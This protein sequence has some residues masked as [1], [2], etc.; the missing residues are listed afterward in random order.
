MNALRRM[1][2]VR[3]AIVVV[4]AFVAVGSWWTYLHAENRDAGS[5]HHAKYHCPMHPNV[6]S[7][8]PGSCPICGMSLELIA[9]SSTSPNMEDLDSGVPG[10]SAVTLTFDRMQAIG[11]KMATAIERESAEPLR[12]TASIAPPDQGFAEVHVRTPGFVE[13]IAVRET[14]VHVAAGQELFAM[15]SPEITQAQAELVAARAI[16]AGP[17]ADVRVTDAAR[18]KLDL[19]GMPAHTI[20]DVAKTGKAARTVSVVAPKA[21]WVNKKNVVLGSYVTP[22][23]TL[24]EIVD[25][26]RVYVVADIFA[27]DLSDVPVGARG[28]FVVDGKPDLTA[29]AA[30]D[31]VYPQTNP[32]ARTARVRLSISNDK[33]RFLPG[34]VG[35]LSIDRAAHRGVF[36]PRDAV[37]DT[38][39]HTYVFV[40]VSKG[41]LVPRGVTVGRAFEDSVEISGVRNGER[42]VSGATFL[43]DSES[44]VRASIHAAEEQRP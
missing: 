19:L 7:D 28:T 29:T 33:M 10:A 13:R 20:D 24:Y 37:V 31:L 5:A 18:S 15:Y 30:V 36:V 42:V 40:E 16:D 4:A 23:A 34:Q 35:T 21:G 38:G 6:V 17:L 41:H 27:R 9:P 3:W 26:S 22:E 25:L 32:E 12:A 44:R 43:V 14:G 8:V 39:E 11:V 1:E 2:I